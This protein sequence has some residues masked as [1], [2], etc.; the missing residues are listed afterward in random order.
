M[1]IS[2]DFKSRE[3]DEKF[4]SMDVLTVKDRNEREEP[5]PVLVSSKP[6]P[7]PVAPAA[8]AAP[9]PPPP[10]PKNQVLQG[11]I[12]YDYAGETGGLQ[13]RQGEIVTIADATNADWW[14]VTTASGGN[15][16]APAS[17]IGK[18]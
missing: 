14:L 16:W 13:V 4:L 12:L 5:T 7:N 15:G 8:A 3:F 1:E 11:K 18:L 10:P 6:T 17:Y 2:K 9:P